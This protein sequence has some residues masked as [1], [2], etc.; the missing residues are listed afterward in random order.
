MC[1][2]CGTLA[3]YFDGGG[4]EGEG[5]AVLGFLQQRRGRH[6]HTHTAVLRGQSSSYF[7][8]SLFH[9]HHLGVVLEVVSV[10]EHPLP[11][12]GRTRLQ[13]P[14]IHQRQLLGRSLGCGRERRERKRPHRCAN[15]HPLPMQTW[16]S[17]PRLNHKRR[18]LSQSRYSCKPPPLYVRIWALPVS[19][20]R[21]HGV[22]ICVFLKLWWMFLSQIFG[23]RG[24]FLS[25]CFYSFSLTFWLL[26]PRLLF[27]QS[28]KICA[29]LF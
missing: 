26:I 21:L 13:A 19:K 16:A 17:R 8:L 11:A 1:S 24:S 14:L 28:H 20:E 4:R 2:T 25:L 15:T 12:R 10:D 22:F 7:T 3:G 5:E 23:L 27:L 9:E 18:Q 29:N 6:T